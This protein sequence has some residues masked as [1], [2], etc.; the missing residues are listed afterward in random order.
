MSQDKSSK[1]F[2][3]DHAQ[4][5]SLMKDNMARQSQQFDSKV[6]EREWVQVSYKKNQKASNLT[7][8]V[9]TKNSFSVLNDVTN[10]Q[11]HSGFGP[12]RD[13]G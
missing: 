2:S 12:G 1:G 5:Q 9:Q 11:E 3:S 8:A 7:L 13:G 10:S 6:N 4:N